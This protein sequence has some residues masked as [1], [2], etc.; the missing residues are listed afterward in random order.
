MP[1]EI[2]SIIWFENLSRGDVALVGGKNASLG[3]LVRA[4]SSEGI[5]VPPG[6]ATTADAFRD[7]LAANRLNETIA[8]TLARLD[9]GKIALREAG[10]AIRAAIM[11]GDWPE[12]TAAAIAAAYRELADRIGVADPAV[13]VRSSATA[14]D[15]PDASFA[16]QQ[17]TL[18]NVR[19][20]R[21]LLNAC[22]RC[23]ASL[24][25]DRA[26]T[27]RR[28]KGFDHSQVALS[29]GV[30]RMARSDLGG[31]GVMFSIDTETG[32]D[33]AVLINAAW[34]LGEN[35]VQGAV[36]PDEYEVFKPL[37]SDPATRPILE[38]RLGA[39]ERKMI[40]AGADGGTRNVPTSKAEQADFVLSDDEILD[41]ARQAVAIERHYGQPMDMEWAKD[42]ETGEVFI[43][44]A[45]PETVE[46]RAAAGAF[47]SYRIRSAGR[48]LLTGLSVGEAVV[49]GRVCL[50]E[51]A[52]DIERFVDGSV[53]VT[54]TTD[55]DWVPVMKRAA[56]IV[57][58]H[59]GR[60]SHAAIVS[61][62]LGLPAV[63]GTGS[64]T[65]LLHD[66]QE[67]TVSCAEGEEGFVYEGTADFEVEDMD[68]GAVPETRTRVMLNLANPA[69]A[70]RWWRLPADG[71]G[72][73]RMEFVVSNAVRAHPM[74]LARFDALRDDEA[75]AEIEALT[76]G[77]ADR[78]DYFVE[79]LARGLSRIA[80]VCHPRPVIIRMSDFKTN[81]YAEL[82]GGRQF[83]P[84]EE[85]PMIGFRGASR[86]YSDAYRDGFALE[87][88]AIRR[89]REE[90][91][92]A[93]VIVMI[94]FCRSPAEADRV[95]AV[96][97]EN[98]LERGRAG[99]EVYVM[100]EIPSNVILAEEFA[101]RF[102]GFSIGSNDL[103]QLTLGVDRDSGQLAA[104][105]DERDPAVLWMIRSVIARAHAA[106]SKVG[107]CGQAPSNDPAFARLL[108][109]AGIDSISVTPDSFLAVKRHVAEA[110]A[111]VPAARV[112]ETH[113]A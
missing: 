8:A 66:E 81:E 69:A 61:R 101:K 77:Y 56:A 33:K 2:R 14:E 28:L 36:N 82:L 74:A 108:V 72:L 34:G 90:M 32:F 97:A 89:L 24:F 100:C 51:S 107:F 6:F 58:D 13:A 52:R 37:L 46:S 73:A 63:V 75:R 91:G 76:R 18:L 95:L 12:R 85:N 59:G 70:F 104:L 1:E 105:F 84:R 25:T 94:P 86:Y 45:R 50:L 11:A 31:A 88:R 78:R 71:V 103:T 92:F 83:E 22:R 20:E 60:T 48:K 87:C 99:L 106:G 41:L 29:V 42:G 39:K 9:A 23:Y 27:Y 15:L 26:I 80:A 112:P 30:Q 102:D 49:A 67:V 54:S 47:K 44:Q 38:K 79:T 93:N 53:L 35:V 57:T 68:L 19:G 40:Y 21:A 4:L 96:M 3:E 65:R 64:A 98:G 5:R 113:E 43:V 109:E 62:E 10:A 16:G 110:E 55:P 17:E 7:Y 111:A